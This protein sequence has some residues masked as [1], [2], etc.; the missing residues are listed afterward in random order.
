M[1]PISLHALVLRRTILVGNAGRALT[2]PAA[3]HTQLAVTVACTA[4]RM[5]SRCRMV[6]AML[7]TS[8]TDPPFN[9]TPLSAYVCLDISVL[10]NRQHPLHALQEPCPLCGEPQTKR[11]AR[12]VLPAIIAL[13]LPTLRPQDS[14]VQDTTVH[15]GRIRQPLQSSTAHWVT[16]VRMELAIPCHVRQVPS[17]MRFCR[18]SAR[19]VR[20]DG[21][22]P[23]ISAHSNKSAIF[24]VLS[25]R[26]CDSIEAGSDHGVVSP[27]DCPPGSYCPENTTSMGEFLCPPGTFGNETN[28][29]RESDC[30]P[31]SGGVYCDAYGMNR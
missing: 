26:Y 10:S 1:P 9:Q 31:C 6:H 17:R 8:A 14:A 18:V 5:A 20:R 22:E 7:A 2:V 19:H 21:E 13:G 3:P 27:V 25:S 23:C 12:C 28:L 4:N 30:K 11:R 29:E 16:T 15:L 24:I